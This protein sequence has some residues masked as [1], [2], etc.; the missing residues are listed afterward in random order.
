MARAVPVQ[1]RFAAKDCL[2]FQAVFFLVHFLKIKAG[3]VQTEKII[4]KTIKQKNITWSKGEFL[5][6]GNY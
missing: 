4:V 2:V 5:L 6:E 1:V 3:D